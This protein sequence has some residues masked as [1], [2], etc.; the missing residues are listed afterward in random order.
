MEVE[1][2]YKRL[3]I[4]QL[5]EEL[6]QK[7][8]N[9]LFAWVYESPQHKKLFYELKDIWDSSKIAQPKNQ[10][11]Q[12]EEWAKLWTEIEKL[13]KKTDTLDG[14]L[15]SRNLREIYK[16]AAILVV[17]FGASWFLLNQL[18]TDDYNTLEVPY[19]ARTN[20]T[21]TDGTKIW[22]NSG[23]TF[24]YPAK[25]DQKDVDV[26]LEGEAFFEVAHLKNRKF[27]VKT[28][29]IN[30][31]VLGTSFNVK[32][33][34]DDDQIE[35][36]LVNGSIRIEGQLDHKTIREPILLKPNQQATFVK[37]K[38]DFQI[39]RIAEKSPQE[40]SLNTQAPATIP[41]ESKASL[42]IFEKVKV[43]DYTSW[44]DHVL[45][46]KSEPLV[47]LVRQMERW[48]DVKIEITDKS[49]KYSRYTG[50]FENETIEQAIEALSLSLP[51]DYTIDKN[52]IEILT[53]K[54]S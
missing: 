30:I 47:D 2:K 44:K 1:D 15:W 25:L 29:T 6:T 42:T 20:I 36:T 7:E 19:G 21:L 24:K 32:S 16:I 51:F 38:S 31:Q 54:D 33:Y 23:T 8:Q 4:G 41:L 14:F 3:L 53:K 52:E 27:N 48:Y 40:D 50:T 39:T 37:G 5:R 13:E 26:F 10:D 35:A 18:Q 45:V 34:D 17:A 46:F 49:L 11:R 9:E 28:S 22:L 43:E 12:Q